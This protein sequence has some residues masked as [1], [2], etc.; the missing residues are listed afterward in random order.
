MVIPWQE[1]DLLRL[2]KTDDTVHVVCIF[3]AE[4]LMHLL[5]HAAGSQHDLLEDVAGCAIADRGGCGE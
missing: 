2:F 4:Y 1:G 3:E 5:K